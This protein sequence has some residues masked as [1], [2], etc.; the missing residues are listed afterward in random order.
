MAITRPSYFTYNFFFEKSVKIA[1]FEKG[2]IEK[3]E[4]FFALILQGNKTTKY[5]TLA[6]TCSFQVL[7]CPSKYHLYM[8]N[9]ILQKDRVNFLMQNYSMDY[10][11]G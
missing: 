7:S 8:L 2:K 1:F 4:K 3:F 6:H 5:R 10:L 11:A 9:S